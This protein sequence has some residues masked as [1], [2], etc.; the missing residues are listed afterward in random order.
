MHE[1]MDGGS[2]GS[3]VSQSVSQCAR[4]DR[5]AS[6]NNLAGNRSQSAAFNIN[7][8]SSLV[9]FSGEGKHPNN[10]AEDPQLLMT[11]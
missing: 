7:D 6:L 2:G 4:T 9:F 5:A 1:W 10:R 3:T 8:P 11:E